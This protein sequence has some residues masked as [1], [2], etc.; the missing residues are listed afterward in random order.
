MR[1]FETRTLD[2]Q[3]HQFLTLWWHRII[4]RRSYVM[5]WKVS[6]S[7]DINQDLGNVW[8]AK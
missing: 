2:E 4:P 1:R 3:A 6:P 8:L 7:H 5:G